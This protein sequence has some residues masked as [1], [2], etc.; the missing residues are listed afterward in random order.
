M[1][2]DN[3]SVFEFRTYHYH[4]AHHPRAIVLAKQYTAEDFTK[5]GLKAPS[6]PTLSYKLIIDDYVYDVN[7]MR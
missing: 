5:L 3:G 2:L 6:T 4:Y 7:R 1:A